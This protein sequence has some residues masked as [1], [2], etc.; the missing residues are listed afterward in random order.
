MKN[1]V[2]AQAVSKQVGIPVDDLVVE[3]IIY[4]EYDNTYEFVIKHYTG[5]EEKPLEQWRMRVSLTKE[6]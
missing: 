3:H 6:I 1:S 5:D 4:T 2:V